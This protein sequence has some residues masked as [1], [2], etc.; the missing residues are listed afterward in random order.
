MRKCKVALLAFLCTLLHSSI[1]F[2]SLFLCSVE[3]L[4]CDSFWVST[5]NIWIPVVIFVGD[6]KGKL[7]GEKGNNRNGTG[8]IKIEREEEPKR[9]PERTQG[10]LHVVDNVIEIRNS[11]VSGEVSEWLSESHWAS[12][13]D[14]GREDKKLQNCS[15][16][17]DVF[18]PSLSRFICLFIVLSLHHTE[19]VFSVCQCHCFS[20]ERFFL[21]LPS[22]LFFLYLSFILSF[23]Q[24][25]S[26]FSHLYFLLLRMLL[27]NDFSFSFFRHFFL[28]G[29]HYEFSMLFLLSFFLFL[30][31]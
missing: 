21:S 16:G 8:V 26:S 23:R 29:S 1:T 27:L 15:N 28:L 11:W 2:H 24:Y 31:P 30:T 14:P 22:W 20:L 10:F 6:Q 18:P 25:S 5:C 9:A 19:Y 12:W 7:E 13:K 3:F 4:N 17:I